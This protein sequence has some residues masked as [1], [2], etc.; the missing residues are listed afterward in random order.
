MYCFA[1]LHSSSAAKR[2]RNKFIFFAR[3]YVNVHI[4]SFPQHRGGEMRKKHEKSTLICR[5]KVSFFMN[6]GD[7]IRGELTAR[8]VGILFVTRLWGFLNFWGRL[9][10]LDIDVF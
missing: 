9:K 1:A 3:L 7:E 4:L 8:V 5:R 10:N 2:N 6:G